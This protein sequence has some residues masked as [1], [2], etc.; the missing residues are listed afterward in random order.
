MARALN[1]ILARALACGGGFPTKT[2]NVCWINSLASHEGISDGAGSPDFHALMQSV[3]LQGRDRVIE[4]HRSRNKLLARERIAK[5]I[6][7]GSPFLELSPFA[8][9]NLYGAQ[10]AIPGIPVIH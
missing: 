5:L 9:Y 7:P 1:A 6:D 2:P 10:P 4:R 3:A 8:G